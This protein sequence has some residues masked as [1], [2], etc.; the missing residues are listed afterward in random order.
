MTKVFE[1]AKREDIPTS[2]AADR[3]AEDRMETIAQVKRTYL[4]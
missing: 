3:L 2:K 1:I 4:G